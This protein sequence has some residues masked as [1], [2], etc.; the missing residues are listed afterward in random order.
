M[1]VEYGPLLDMKAAVYSGMMTEGIGLL[2]ANCPSGNCSWPLTPSIAV[3]GGCAPSTYTTT[4]CNSSY[5]NYTMASGSVSTLYNQ[6]AGDNVVEFQV[7]SSYGA[8][9]N[10]RRYDK[11]YI[12]NFDMFGAP[13]G[14]YSSGWDN[15][16]TISSECALWMCVQTFNV[17][18]RSGQQVESVVASYSNMN[19]TPPESADGT[20]A[21]IFT[22]LPADLH[23]T[24][25]TNFT[26]NYFAWAA[27]ATIP[28]R[29][30]ERDRNTQHCIP[31]IFQ[32]HHRSNLER[33]AEPRQVDQQRS[34]Q[35]DEKCAHWLLTI[36]SHLQRHSI[37]ARRQ[38][39]LGVDRL[40]RGDCALLIHLL[41]DCHRENG[42]ESGRS[43][44]GKPAGFSFLRR[45]SRH[46]ANH[47]RPHASSSWH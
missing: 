41:G 29:S 9:F 43:V 26:V 32:R 35:H 13:Y 18:T 38:G 42:Q 37:P 36:A 4:S 27:L 45:G 46:E 15:K 28:S 19:S 23:G 6:P 40:T 17:S 31:R 30:G 21:L 47:L 24:V 5:C 8:H 1:I 2:E 16:S 12:A 22:D 14:S 39:A 33:H 25:R 20:T 44:E 7:Q 10:T 34:H 11:L 3:C